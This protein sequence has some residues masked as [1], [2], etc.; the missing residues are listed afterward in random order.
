[1]GPETAT[2]LSDLDVVRYYTNSAVQSSSSSTTGLCVI[3]IYAD[4]SATLLAVIRF[5]TS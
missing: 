3:T 4:F 5:T 1:M 2:L